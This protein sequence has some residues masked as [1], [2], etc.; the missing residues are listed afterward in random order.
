[1]EHNLAGT[2][3]KRWVFMHRLIHTCWMKHTSCRG[4]CD[5]AVAA[6][7]A[8]AVTSKCKTMCKVFSLPRLVS[9]VRLGFCSAPPPSRTS[10]AAL[11]AACQTLRLPLALRMLDPSSIRI[12]HALFHQIMYPCDTSVSSCIEFPY[13]LGFSHT[14]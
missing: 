3:L 8:V 9:F 13:L 12:H 7:V 14:F 5:A 6:G 1:M 2:S 11:P 4:S 10:S